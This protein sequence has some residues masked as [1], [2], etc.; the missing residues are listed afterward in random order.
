MEFKY[1]LAEQVKN[2][3]SEVLK[4]EHA[5]VSNT[6]WPLN[7]FDRRLTVGQRSGPNNAITQPSSGNPKYFVST[8]L[9]KDGN[10][11]PKY[12]K[13][14]LL[15]DTNRDMDVKP[16]YIGAKSETESNI[17]S[18]EKLIDSLIESSFDKNAS[19][20]DAAGKTV[21]N[22]T[23]TKN[24]EPNDEVK[25]NTTNAS[26]KNETT[27]IL[28][29]NLTNENIDKN[30]YSDDMFN[31]SNDFSQMIANLSKRIDRQNNTSLEIMKYRT[32]T[33]DFEDES[34]SSTSE[35]P[36]ETTPYKETENSTTE[37][38]TEPTVYETKTTRKIRKR[39]VRRLQNGKNN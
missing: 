5:D 21:V 7:K 23:I 20:P 9:D 8:F 15:N 1:H 24:Q 38:I 25:D 31:N 30:K 6:R 26:M 12:F 39:I 29:M 10:N 33:R 2:M 22:E 17:I 36:I 28:S 11:P 34:V 16:I 14:E 32:E 3:K 27:N 19:S 13:R 37:H 35:K 4:T 18:L